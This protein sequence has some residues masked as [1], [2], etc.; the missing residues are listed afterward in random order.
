MGFLGFRVDGGNVAPLGGLVVRRNCNYHDWGRSR[1]R[2]KI[3][4]I[5]ILNVESKA[6]VTSKLTL[7]YDCNTI[8]LSY[9]IVP[10]C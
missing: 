6:L 7:L 10:C 3:S 4:S 5:N 2:C 9:Y 1:E 8:L